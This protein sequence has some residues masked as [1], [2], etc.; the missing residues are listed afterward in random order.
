V[1]APT[2]S[3]MTG[4]ELAAAAGA[5]KAIHEA[6][7]DDESLKQ[8]LREKAKDSPAML[9]AAESHARRIA[10]KQEILLKLFMP[11]AVLLGISRDYF[12]SDFASDMAEKIKDIP[13]DQL[14]PPKGSV[15]GP[16]VQAL[17]YSLDEPDLKEMYLN[18]LATA[19]DG[20]CSEIA[21][22]SF[23]EVIRQLSSEEAKLL[24]GFLSDDHPIVRVKKSTQDE[25]GYLVLLSHLTPLVDLED[26]TPDADPSMPIYV[27]NWIRLGLVTVHYDAYLIGV[28]SYK[29]VESR[30]EY[31]ELCAAH[32]QD[33][34]LVDYDR[35]VLSPTAFGRRFI[36]AVTA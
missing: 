20:R 19:V 24:K 1:S 33:E 26:G 15:A 4:G 35:G 27:D 7:K 21:H 17:S 2:L 34:V 36:E 14:K 32:R 25:V 28:E 22:P 12:S 30:P 31:L 13:E 29:W 5:A 23:A 9:A 3:Y 8:Q 6:A 10:V 18:L 11:L 16:T